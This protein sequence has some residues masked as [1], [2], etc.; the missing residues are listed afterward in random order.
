MGR[1]DA[2][3]RGDLF[4]AILLQS[5]IADKNN[6]PEQ[7]NDYPEQVVETLFLFWKIFK[8]P[9]G[10]I[11]TKR[12]KSKYNDWTSELQELQIICPTNKIMEWAMNTAFNKYNNISSKFIIAR[13]LA[14]KKLL[15]DAMRELPKPETH[16][17]EIKSEPINKSQL[18]DIKSIFK[19]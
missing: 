14:I 1:T 5:K 16:K 12:Q 6:R 18:R 7:I 10:A 17:E 19:E 4:D 15:I 8:L 13:P 9:S 3:K 11:P 2:V